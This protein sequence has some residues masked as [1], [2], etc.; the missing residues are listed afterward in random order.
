MT[1][2]GRRLLRVFGRSGGFASPSPL[3]SPPRRRRNSIGTVPSP[4]AA[5]P[6][7]P[8]GGPIL[9]AGIREPARRDGLGELR[10][11]AFHLGR[12]LGLERPSAIDD[13][14]RRLPDEG[15]VR[16]TGTSGGEASLGLSKLLLEPLPVA[17]R[18]GRGRT[19]NERLERPSHDDER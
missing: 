8:F 6:T 12:Q 4:P 3:A 15:R 14:R 13:V 17:T 16:E 11:K 10:A 18:L 1:S 2:S 7:H 5:H 9:A 19:A